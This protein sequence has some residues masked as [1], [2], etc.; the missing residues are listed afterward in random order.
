MTETAPPPRQEPDLGEPGAYDLSDPAFV[1]DREAGRRWLTAPRPI[2][3]G[4]SLDGSPCWVVTRYEDARLVLTDPRFTSRPPGQSHAAGMRAQGVPEDVVPLLDSNLLCMDR[5]DHGRVRPLVTL[6]FSARRVRTMRPAIEGMVGELLDALD[7]D[8]ENDLIA[9]FADPLPIR[10]VSHLIGVDEEHREQWLQWA[11]TFNGPVPPPPDVLAPAL[12]GMVE[13]IRHLI[14]ER[15]R[16]PGDDLLSDLIRTHDE[17]GERLTDDELAALAILVIQAGHDSVRQLIALGVL[18]LLENPD[19]FELIRS[20]RT[21]WSSGLAEIMRHAAPVKHAF[22][23]FPTEPVEVGGVTVTPGEGVLVVL[24]AANRDPAEFPD[25]GVLDVTR[26]PNPHLGF[27]RGPH[28]CPG[29]TLAMTEVE[30]ALKALFTRF[31]K[32]RLAVPAEEIAPQFLI[33]VRRLPVLLG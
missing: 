24:A 1:T 16:K 17:D 3:R 22:R 13:V 9:R 6:A 14:A 29:S 30:I 27:S 8:A 21:T 19:Q 11:H 10:V 2:C 7:P 23:R 26:S 32:V 31:P 33:G 25:P 4:R 20:G 18:T 15:R 12:R 28:F 5:E